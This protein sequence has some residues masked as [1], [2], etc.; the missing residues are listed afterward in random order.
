M[1]SF[2]VWLARLILPRG[3]VITLPPERMARMRE[4]LLRGWG[5]PAG[6]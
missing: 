2:R 5:P 6:P 1:H 4:A 3:L